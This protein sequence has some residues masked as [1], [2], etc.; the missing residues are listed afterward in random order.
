MSNNKSL[1]VY[2][3]QSGNSKFIAETIAQEIKAD[4]LEIKTRKSLPKATFFKL[5]IGGMQVIFKSKPELLPFDK[6]PTDYDLIIIGT[7]VWASSYASPLNTFFSKVQINGKKIAL[8]CCCG[9][10]QGK[11]FEN[12]KNVLKGNQFLGELELK[13]PLN[14]KEE[15]IRKTREWART[16]N[17]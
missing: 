2:F 16:I 11:T 12:M 5:F 13:S 7:P 8:Y 17:S 10:S 6:N 1:V 9:G 4:T 15:S 14:S 3:S